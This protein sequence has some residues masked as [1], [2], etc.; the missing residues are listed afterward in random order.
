MQFPHNQTTVHQYHSF[1]G[2][3]KSV[4]VLLCS[5]HVE[6][7]FCDSLT[8]NR[9]HDIETKIQRRVSKGQLLGSHLKSRGETSMCFMWG[10]AQ[11]WQL[12]NEQIGQTL[13]IGARQKNFSY[14]K[15]RLSR[16]SVL[17]AEK[18]SLSCLCSIWIVCFECPCVMNSF[19]AE[20]CF[21]LIHFKFIVC[22]VCCQ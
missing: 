14:A 3:D 7:D 13:S 1:T 18:K 20:M 21:H 12:K 15:K 5:S 17:T 8:L 6:C 19:T 2:L 10:G 4:L 16:D 22:C 9:L 11:E